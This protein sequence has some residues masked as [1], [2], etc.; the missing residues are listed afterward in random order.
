MWADVPRDLSFF[1]LGILAGRNG[2]IEKIHRSRGIQLLGLSAGLA[3]LYTAAAVLRVPLLWGG[4]GNWRYG[5]FCIWES[6][7]CFSTCFALVIF[8]RETL[9]RAGPGF[10]ALA[11]AI[12][13]VYLFHVP[14][15]VAFQYLFGLASLGPWIAFAAVSICAVPV[16]FALVLLLR[17]IPGVNRIL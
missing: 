7:F 5:F 4:V 8:F 3:A 11:A 2:W 10:R 12:F 15:V 13:G 9:N 1:V 14:V 17:R 16:S 6:L